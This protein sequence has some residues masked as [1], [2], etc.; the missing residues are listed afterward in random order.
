MQW[1][2]KKPPGRFDSYLEW[3]SKPHS[4]WKNELELFLPAGKQTDSSIFRKFLMRR[5][6]PTHLRSCLWLGGLTNNWLGRT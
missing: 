4:K 6:F 3:K 1:G 5:R 2:G